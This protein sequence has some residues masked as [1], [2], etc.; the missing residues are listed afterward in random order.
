LKVFEQELASSYG[1]VPESVVNLLFV[2]K[3]KRFA[4]HLRIKKVVLMGK[5]FRL[6]LRLTQ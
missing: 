4:S 6:F 5:Q 1:E 3:I 2:M